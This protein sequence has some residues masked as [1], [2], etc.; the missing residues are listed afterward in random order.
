MTDFLIVTSK[1][2]I[3]S[4]N[5]RDNLLNSDLFKF[6][7]AKYKWKGNPLFILQDIFSDSSKSIGLKNNKVFLGLINERLIFLNDLELEKSDF[8]PDILIFASRHTSKE[9]RPAFLV[10]ATGNWS[11]D[12]NFG[13][14]PKEI[15]HSSA[16]LVKAGFLSLEEQKEQLKNLDFLVDFLVDLEVSHHGPTNLEKP[17]IFME[18]GSSKKEWIIKEAAKIVA[19]SIINA[20]FKYLDFKLNKLIE[21]GIGFGGT[22]YAPQFKKLILEN[23]IA[24]SFICPKYFVQELNKD[25][26]TQMINKN[27]EKIDYFVIDWKGLNAQDKHYLIPLLEEFDIPIKKTKDF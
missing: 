25:I 12:T 20:I 1:E 3:A 27:T 5:I 10:H 23:N 19:N 7:L 2:D 15:S 22:H 13:G 6:E 4:M 18:L 16:L 17:L 11:K 24:I 21:I 26:I 14:N 8:N 9:L